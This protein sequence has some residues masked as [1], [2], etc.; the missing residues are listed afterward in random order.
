MYVRLFCYF[1]YQQQQQYQLTLVIVVIAKQ[2]AI[3]KNIYIKTSPQNSNLETLYFY[4]IDLKMDKY[5]DQNV[6]NIRYNF[7]IT[8]V[9]RHV[10]RGQKKDDS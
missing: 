4:I 2:T 9:T 10:T 6:L 3:R 5:D 7:T 8:L 1:I